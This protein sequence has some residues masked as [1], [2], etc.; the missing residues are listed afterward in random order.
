MFLLGL[1]L[2]HMSITPSA[3][4]EI[5]QVCRSVTLAQCQAV[6]ARALQLESAREVTRFL[7]AELHK[8]APELSGQ[9]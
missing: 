3:I 6:A 8:V 7:Q 5:K 4:A 9:A 1:G 2:R